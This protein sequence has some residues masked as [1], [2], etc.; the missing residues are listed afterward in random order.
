MTEHQFEEV[1]KTIESM[2]EKLSELAY[3]FEG[4]RSLTQAGLVWTY[5]DITPEEMKQSIKEEALEAVENLLKEL[6]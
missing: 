1:K 2:H 4:A 5:G 3:T 6:K